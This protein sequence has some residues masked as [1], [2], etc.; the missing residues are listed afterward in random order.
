M[1]RGS[2]SWQNVRDSLPGRHWPFCKACD[3]FFPP[4]LLIPKY[5]GC[6][7]LGCMVMAVA[8]A[9]GISK[10]LAFD[11]VPK[12]VEF[13]KAFGADY[14]SLVPPKPEGRKYHEWAEAWKVTALT[15]AG[16][17]L[18]GTDVVVE[19][20]GAELAMHAGMSFV[21]MGGTCKRSHPTL[22]DDPEI[23]G[24]FFFRCSSRSRTSRDALPDVLC[25]R[26][27]DRSDRDRSLHGWMLPSSD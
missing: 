23:P 22:V 2:F 11:V 10:I 14:A 17:D 26:K 12:R 5:S 25:R 21:H 19:A 8:Q 24:G 20:S 27:R 9:F 1:S 16:V 13:A 3:I 7:P 6:G 18:W 4:D 15:E